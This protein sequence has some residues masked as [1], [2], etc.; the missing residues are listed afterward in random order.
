MVTK[1]TDTE[2]LNRLAAAYDTTLTAGRKAL[3]Q[4]TTAREG[5]TGNTRTTASTGDVNRCQ[6]QCTP[7]SARAQVAEG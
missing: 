7:E 3:A 6:R 5:L 2:L 4:K 1:S